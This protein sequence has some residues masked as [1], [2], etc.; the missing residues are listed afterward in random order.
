[1]GG[2]NKHH[3]WNRIKYT[4]SS[5]SVVCH[6]PVEQHLDEQSSNSIVQPI[7]TSTPSNSN[8]SSSQLND[9]SNLKRKRGECRSIDHEADSPRSKVFKE[10][11][12][13]GIGKGESV[14]CEAATN[15]ANLRE[16][17]DAEL[18]RIFDECAGS[19]L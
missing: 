9:K 19:S 17:D 14:E 6:G 2:C 7:I 12:G 5:S 10:T 15:E 13:E 11:N 4:N 18:N 16:L 8:P 3:E 1:M